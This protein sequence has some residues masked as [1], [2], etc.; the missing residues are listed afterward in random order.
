MP[1]LASTDVT[2]TPDEVH[3]FRMGSKLKSG[4]SKVEFGNGSLTY[5]SGGVPLPDF[6]K[7]DLVRSISSLKIVDQD[8]STG[9]V[10]MMDHANK[11]LRGYQAPAR[12]HDHDFS[13]QSSGA[14]GTNMTIGISADATSATV[15]GGSG[16]TAERTLSTNTPIESETIAPAE[17][18][19]LATSATPA[20]QTLYIEAQGW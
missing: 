15:E 4:V 16:V 3:P 20:A 18:S 11:K 19:E 5:P 6:E 7:W 14:I 8:D 9:I 17:L 2:I 13:V 1:A 12:T 10:W